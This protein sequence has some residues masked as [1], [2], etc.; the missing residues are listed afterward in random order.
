[1]KHVYAVAFFRS[2]N[3]LFLI[4]STVPE[5]RLIAYG[6]L[7]RGDETI[8]CSLGELELRNN[9]SNTE[10]RVRQGR[11]RYAFDRKKRSLSRRFRQPELIETQSREVELLNYVNQKPR[12][13]PSIFPMGLITF[14]WL[15]GIR[16]AYTGSGAMLLAFS[17]IENAPRRDLFLFDCRTGGAAWCRR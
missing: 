9:I 11:R 3:R 8:R 4:D 1:M 15:P 12:W 2:R 17:L 16:S 5:F 10:K 6:D 13:L 7:V 14:C